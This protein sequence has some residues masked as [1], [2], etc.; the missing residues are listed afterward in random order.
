MYISYIK[1]TYT[2]VYLL[3]KIPHATSH[4]QKIINKQINVT[5]GMMVSLKKKKLTLCLNDEFY[6]QIPKVKVRRVNQKGWGR[7]ALE[8]KRREEKAF[9]SFSFQQ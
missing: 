5:R 3:H 6:S 7:C 4:G 1:Q 9:I 8:V 2:Y